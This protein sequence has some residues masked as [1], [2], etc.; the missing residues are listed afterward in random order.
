MFVDEL[1]YVNIPPELLSNLNGDVIVK[2]DVTV[3]TSDNEIFK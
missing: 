2:F 3:T 1:L